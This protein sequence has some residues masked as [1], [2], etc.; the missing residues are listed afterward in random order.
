[1][2]LLERN[3]LGRPEMIISKVNCASME[4]AAYT[5]HGLF[6]TICFDET[7]VGKTID[8][9]IVG[10]AVTTPGHCKLAASLQRGGS[11]SSA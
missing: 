5:L 9:T 10:R 11:L 1:M 3:V 4:P 2:A 7:V 8:E 6:Y